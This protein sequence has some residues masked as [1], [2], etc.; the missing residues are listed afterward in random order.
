[1]RSKTRT[2][3]AYGIACTPPD[4]LPR[5]ESCPRCGGLLAVNQDGWKICHACGYASP[6]GTASPPRSAHSG[7]VTPTVVRACV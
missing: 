4:P 5:A 2:S 7:I 1:M 6:P 3:R